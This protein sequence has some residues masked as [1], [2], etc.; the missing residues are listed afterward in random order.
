[1]DLDRY[2]VTHQPTW[3]RLEALNKKFG[4]P[5]KLAAGEVRELVH[6]YR[7]VS[8]DLSYARATFDDPALTGHLTRLVGTTSAIIYGSRPRTWTNVGTF[9]LSTFPAAVW[10]ARWFV[11]VSAALTLVP[12]LV[13][14]VW[15]ANSPDA[16][17]AALPDA[18]RDAYLN[19]DF[20]SYYESERA[21]Q[22]ASHVFTNNIGVGILAFGGGILLGI[23]TAIVLLTTEPTSVRPAGSSP[24]TANQPSSGA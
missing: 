8:A 11:M 7:R 15:L 21:S 24:S 9:F 20:E 18:A 3:Q 2:L 4:A 1:V 6:L 16:A 14:G 22:F 12:A 17:H 10:R 5:R 19:H 23:P 13:M